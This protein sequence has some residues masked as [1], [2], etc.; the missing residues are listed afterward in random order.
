MGIEE[1]LA[2]LHV[3]ESIAVSVLVWRSFVADK[4]RAELM[5]EIRE[6]GR[7]VQALVNDLL[8][9]TDLRGEGR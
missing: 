5:D 6:S 9:R 4:E 3:G 8:E 7:W 1:I 2:L